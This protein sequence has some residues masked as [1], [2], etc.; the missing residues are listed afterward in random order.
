MILQ[1]KIVE[2]L[3]L[4]FIIVYYK[5]NYF[6]TTIS[7]VVKRINIMRTLFAAQNVTE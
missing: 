5:F 6:L 1:C 4:F 3:F 7:F 2:L